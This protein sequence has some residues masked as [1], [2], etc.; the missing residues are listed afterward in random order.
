MSSPHTFDD[1]DAQ[2]LRLLQ[3]D[4][5]LPN[6][7]LAQAVGLS[8]AATHER[9]QRLLREGYILGFEGVLNPALLGAGLLVFVELRL[10]AHG[11]GV[12]TAFKAAVQAQPEILECH[13]V[14]GSFDYL[15]KV[16]V[17]DMEAY[18]R[19]VAEVV[20][21]LPGVRQVRTYTAMEEV[22]NTAKLAL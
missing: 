11:D 10:Q 16:R 2:L 14:A 3:D 12:H 15:V 21:A 22:K 7:K 9:V 5:R 18:R 4:A 17:A 1:I 19:V 20:W 13:E 8:P 6:L